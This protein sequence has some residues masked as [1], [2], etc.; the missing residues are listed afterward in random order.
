MIKSTA[1]RTLSLLLMLAM[2]LSLF[3][4]LTLLANAAEP[5]SASEVNYRK[6]GK[7]IYNWGKRDTTAT[8]LTTYAQ[9]YYTGSYSYAM[10][11]SKSG[12]TS[13][14]AKDIYESALG[15]AISAMLKSKNPSETSYDGTKNLYQYTDCEQN[16]NKISSFYSGVS[17]GP[18]WDYGK[19]W[20]RE[21][22]W[23]NSKGLNGNDENDIM[24]LR[25]T[26]V[27]ENSDRG[28]K[29]YGESSSTY[30]DPNCEG[31]DLRGDVARLMLQHLMRWG[32]TNKFYGAGGVMENRIVLLKW[33]EEDP[34][35]TWEMGRNDAVQAII[36]V[37]NVFVD[38]PELAFRLLGAEV[39][40]GYPT[41]SN[42][43][44]TVSYE[45]TARSD[46]DTCGSVSVSGKTIT[47]TAKEGC[48]INDAKP[49]TVTPV[50]AATVTRSG[51]V[52]TVSGMKSDCTV[53]INFVRKQ[54][55]TVVFNVPS[56]VSLVGVSA[57]G[58][59]SGIYV[60]DSIRL[61][62]VTGKPNNTEYQFY[63]WATASVAK[64][65]T[66]P[67]VKAANAAYTVTG[68]TTTFYPVFSLK[69]GDVTYYDSNPLL[70][71]CKH[72][73][74]EKQHLDATCTT[75][76]YDR[77]VCTDCGMDL[78][79]EQFPAKGHS[80]ENGKC[81][82][83]GAADPNVKPTNY[84]KYTD[85][86]DLAVESWYKDGISYALEH[87]L[88]NGVGKR[89]FDPEGD[90]TRAMFVTIL[91]RAETSPSVEGKQNRFTDV[92]TGEWYTD[93][94]IWA[95]DCGIVNGTSQTTYDPNA[96]I[97]REQIATILYRYSKAAKSDKALSAFPDAGTVSSYAL[98]AMR[99]AVEQQIISGKD[100]KLA[101]QENATRAQIATILMR[102]LKK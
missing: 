9:S 7:Y 54:A 48:K 85:F 70:T 23:P 13:T 37:R 27:N 51:N 99:W 15:T 96:P 6:S 94:V 11:S 50:G 72:E 71:E 36:G 22:T 93:A 49:Y 61:A 57:N 64:T 98:D 33:L 86:S 17:I 88:M 34:V 56:G 90:V 69:Q 39:P 89:E 4:G 2:V 81:T 80:F 66:A 58:M 45:L 31:Q 44:K 87:G 95:A 76:G 65:T 100:G 19:T 8:F 26:S 75:A 41:P 68:A 62:S 21:H 25:P 5:T 59:I 78:A 77:T 32:N 20:N 18:K 14:S 3:S 42:G 63:G 73:H 10:L 102:Y 28:N 52:F 47:A 91:Y 1:K 35:D 79:G 29:A 55:A 83:C 74:T 60:G 40:A 46:D 53:T 97:T 38:Y 82:V 16:G 101:P 43:G 12:S 84:P 67:S 92:G 30:Y 24:M